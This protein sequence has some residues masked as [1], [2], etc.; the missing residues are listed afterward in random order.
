MGQDDE[1]DDEDNG[2]A[3]AVCTFDGPDEA[4]SLTRSRDDAHKGGRTG[5]KIGFKVLRDEDAA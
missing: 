4:I 2:E 3:P 1:V 5:R